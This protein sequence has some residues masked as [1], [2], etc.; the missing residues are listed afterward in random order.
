[1]GIARGRFCVGQTVPEATI[2]RPGLWLLF[3]VALPVVV[4][5][6]VERIPLLTPLWRAAEKRRHNISIH[7]LDVCV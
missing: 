2:R 3:A 6:A 4:G 7:V 1:M 5:S